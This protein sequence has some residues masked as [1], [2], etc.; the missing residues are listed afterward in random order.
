MPPYVAPHLNQFHRIKPDGTPGPAWPKT[1]GRDFNALNCWAAIGAIAGAHGSVGEWLPTPPQI[2]EES[3]D[4]KGGANVADIARVL[5]AHGLTANAPKGGATWAQIETKLVAGW[6][7]CIATDYEYVPDAKSCQPTFDD[8]HMLGIRPVA[9]D[10]QGRRQVDDPLCDRIRL[11][12]EHVIREA[13]RACA[14]QVGSV[15]LL[16]C[17][18]KPKPRPVPPPPSPV[19]PKD[20]QIADLTAKVATLEEALAAAVQESADRQR[21]IDLMVAIGTGQESLT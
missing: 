17:F 6:Y 16:V 1:W 2:R 4:R 5:R 13:A 18:V 10:A 3:G 14:D 11:Y 12:P 8:W 9:V 15:G 19:D 21:R 20:R 7:V